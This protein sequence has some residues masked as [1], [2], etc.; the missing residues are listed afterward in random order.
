MRRMGRDEGDRLGKIREREVEAKMERDKKM[1][2]DRGRITI[3][4]LSEP[5]AWGNSASADDLQPKYERQRQTE[6]N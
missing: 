2:G 4:R 5:S 3:T 1:V 6:I